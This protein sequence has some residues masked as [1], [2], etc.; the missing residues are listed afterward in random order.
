NYEQFNIA[1]SQW[2]IPAG[3]EFDEYAIIDY[4]TTKEDAQ[5]VIKNACAIFLLGG[6]AAVQ[7][8]FLDEYDILT[9]IND[10]NASVIM[11]VS[12]GAMNMSAKWISSKHISIGSAR[13][14][15]GKSSVTDGLGL[16]NFAF[17]AHIDINNSALFERDLFPLS[18]TIDIYAGCYES[19]IRVKDGKKEFYGDVYL[20]SNSNIQKM[21]ESSAS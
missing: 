13:Y 20:I 3:V 12:A 21:E 10:S 16:G 7:R 1:E 18:Q 2:L 6:K 15:A 14:T 4:R 11:G 19:V 17:E 9:A 8:A 5:N